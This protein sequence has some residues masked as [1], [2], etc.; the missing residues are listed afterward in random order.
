[1]RKLYRLLK[2]SPELKKD[3]ILQ[4]D[5]DNGDQGFSILTKEYLKHSDQGGLSYSRKTVMNSPE[6]FEEVFDLSKI[7]Y[8]TKSELDKVKELL[9]SPNF[10]KFVKKK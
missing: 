2:D 9:K 1:M 10:N 4:E 6:W 7:F 3:A 5:C 8:V